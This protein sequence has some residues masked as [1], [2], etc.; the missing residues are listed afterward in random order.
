MNTKIIL[1]QTSGPP[2]TA[3]RPYLQAEMTPHNSQAIPT[4]INTISKQQTEFKEILEDLD[5]WL[6]QRSII[7]R[8]K[9]ITNNQEKTTQTNMLDGIYQWAKITQATL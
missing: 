4:Q 6:S 2:N 9:T 3:S 7:V 1:K 5:R 8:S